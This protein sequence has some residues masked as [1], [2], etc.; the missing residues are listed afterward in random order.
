VKETETKDTVSSAEVPP[1]TTTPAE[2]KQIEP[3]EGKQIE[4][5][6][7][8]GD[9]KA[10]MEEPTSSLVVQEIPSATGKP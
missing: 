7:P 3:A 4:S 5:A 1:P 10:E 2:D 8:G 9:Q 6:D